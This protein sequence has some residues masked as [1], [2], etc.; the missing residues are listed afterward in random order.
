[1]CVCESI[2]S[3]AS[4]TSIHLD[5]SIP[6]CIHPPLCHRSVGAGVLE[7]EVEAGQE[8]VEGR[9]KVLHISIEEGR[10]R[11]VNNMYMHVIQ[12]EAKAESLV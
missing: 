6:P 11:N 9:H 8:E 1:M 4:C 12:R 2:D 5:P 10:R 7:D 3:N